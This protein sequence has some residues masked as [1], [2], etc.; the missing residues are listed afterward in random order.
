MK[1]QHIL[2]LPFLI[3]ATSSVSGQVLVPSLY[4]IGTDVNQDS[5]ADSFT[6]AVSGG[7]RVKLDYTPL[8]FPSHIVTRSL[9]HFDLTGIT[10]VDSAVFD[11]MAFGS[12]SAGN[13]FFK[14]LLYADDASVTLSDFNVAGA[15]IDTRFGSASFLQS[16]NVTSLLNGV[17]ASG[18]SYMDIRHEINLPV[19]GNPIIKVDLLTFLPRILIRNHARSLLS[20]VQSRSQPLQ[21]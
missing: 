17:L 2:T 18:A 4:G 11:F 3:L 6:T 21:C 13:Y 10:H 12:T 14:T 19:G 7:F 20:L 8:P 15:I 1:L 16:I 5:V 9:L